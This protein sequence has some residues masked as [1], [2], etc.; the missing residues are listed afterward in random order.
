MTA[1]YPLE[2]FTILKRRA[3]V[4]IAVFTVI[5]LAGLIVALNW[6][7]Y[8]ATATIEVAQPEISMETLSAGNNRPVSQEAL[9]DL[10][11]SRLKQKVL[12]I[13]SLGEIIAK[14]NLYPDA[15]QTTPITRIARN[16]RRHVTVSLQSTALA[17]PASATKAT[18]DQL[19]AI[20]FSVSFEYDDPS[21]AQKTVN[22]L[23]SRFLDEDLKE[24]REMAENTA[25]FLEGQLD[26][27]SESLE[28][29]EKEIAEFRAQNGDMRPDALGF[30]QQASIASASRLM[31]LESELTANLGRIGALKA[32]LTQT[33]PYLSVVDNEEGE[34]ISPPAVRLRALESEF[35]A[36]TS[37][38]GPNHPD[39]VSTERQIRALKRQARSARSGDIVNDADN[40]A[41]L[42]IL[43]QLT[44]AEK[45]QEALETQRD[46]VREQQQSFQQAIIANPQAEQ[47]LAG[48]TR[49]YDNMISLYREL[50][51]RKL[52]A[53]MSRTIEE[54][55]SGRRLAVID[56]PELPLSTS[57]PRKL[58][59]AAAII[60]AGFIATAVVLGLYLLTPTV[61]G[62]NHLESLIGTT[63]LV[64]VPRLKTFDEKITIRRLVILAVLLAA[65]IVAIVL[66]INI[67]SIP[68][69]F[70]QDFLQ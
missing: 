39:V 22:E 11:I 2:Y 4:F 56:P 21:L 23:V 34:L 54:G 30:N 64:R 25:N 40:P 33:E 38:Y 51:A 45:Q 18:A 35:A 59:L 31:N 46:T 36:L 14:L 13:S 32:Q 16:M 65:L 50:K 61:I 26:M 8:S 7:K 1:F 68:L 55:H 6:S 20:A 27:L 28:E 52:A 69:G 29:K 44:A 67:L 24:R 41:Y 19:S 37:K 43:A 70:I 17:N 60:I 3:P 9:A 57:P 62:P 48:L 12:S 66:A 63:P 42:Q 15:R 49:D 53:D 47:K 10:Q 58:L 5:F